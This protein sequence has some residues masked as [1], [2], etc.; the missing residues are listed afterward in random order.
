MQIVANVVTDTQRTCIRLLYRTPISTTRRRGRPNCTAKSPSASPNG[1]QSR[2]RHLHSELDVDHREPQP[3][4]P[5]W[6][7]EPFGQR[8]PSVYSLTPRAANSTPRESEYLQH[9]CDG[10]TAA[11]VKNSNIYDTA[12]DRDHERHRPA[13]MD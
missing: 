6:T 9:V 10:S 3:V 8:T 11:Q 4:P 7:P 1:H 2:P 12:S 13:R 5:L